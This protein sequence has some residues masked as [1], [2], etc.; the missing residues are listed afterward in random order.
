MPQIVEADT[1][2]V[3][4]LTQRTPAG[5]KVSDMPFVI[6][7][8]EQVWRPR[9]LGFS[10]QSRQYFKS[11]RRQWRRVVVSLLGTRGRL[12]PAPLFEIDLVCPSR[13]RLPA[14]ASRQ[15]YQPDAIGCTL[16]RMSFERISQP[17]KFGRFQVA[18]APDLVVAVNRMLARV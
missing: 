16:T 4:R 5:L 12:H 1:F 10:H 18:L 11:G 14:T 13:H 7:A 17:G 3:G 9:L 8:G 6:S 15:H 2:K